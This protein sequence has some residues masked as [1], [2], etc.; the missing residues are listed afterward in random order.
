MAL[1]PQDFLIPDFLFIGRV[2]I[3][4]ILCPLNYLLVSVHI[5]A[6]CIHKEPSFIFFFASSSPN[7][8]FI[9]YHFHFLLPVFPS[10][11]FPRPVQEGRGG[12]RKEKGGYTAVESADIG[13]GC[14]E[15]YI[16]ICFLVL[17]C[18]HVSRPQ[19]STCTMVIIRW[20]Q[21]MVV[22]SWTQST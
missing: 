14:S 11:F 6:I 22:I 18:I 5:Q 12:G 4:D 10:V 13:I 21:K 1:C 17:G 19:V 20:A 9:C 2:F 7:S 15:V 16:C 8:F 3:I